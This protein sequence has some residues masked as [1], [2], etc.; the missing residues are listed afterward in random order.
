MRAELDQ[1][2]GGEQRR[3]QE[4]ASGG[5]ERDSIG[6]DARDFDRRSRE[7]TELVYQVERILILE[8][9]AANGSSAPL[10]EESQSQKM[11]ILLQSEL[12]RRDRISVRIPVGM[13]E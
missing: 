8:G 4:A 10:A 9:H 6:M 3:D 5:Q 1:E 2:M 11:L 13:G 7:K 12:R